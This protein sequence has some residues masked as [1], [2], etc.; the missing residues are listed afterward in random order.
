MGRAAGHGGPPDLLLCE[1]TQHHTGGLRLA[2][3]P[4]HAMCNCDLAPQLDCVS[5]TILLG[6]VQVAV[7]T[8]GASSVKIQ[9][10]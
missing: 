5:F 3:L 6:R 1:N 2:S 9:T 4:G 10:P 7:E 8:C